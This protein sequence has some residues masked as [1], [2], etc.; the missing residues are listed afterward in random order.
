MGID[1]SQNESTR[2]AEIWSVILT[3]LGRTCTKHRKVHKIPQG[4]TMY[5]IVNNNTTRL[6]SSVP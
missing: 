2:S 5:R 3:V 1:S 4:G 6:F